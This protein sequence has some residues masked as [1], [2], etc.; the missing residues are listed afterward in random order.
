MNLGSSQAGMV[1][2][3]SVATIPSIP[4]R[5]RY[6]VLLIAFL[7]TMIHYLD[8]ACLSVAAPGMSKDLNLSRMQ[9]GYVFVAFDLAYAIFGIPVSWLGG[10]DRTAEARHRH[11]CYLVNPYDSH[12]IRSRIDR[13]SGNPLRVR[14]GGV[15]RISDAVKGLG[16][17][18][19]SRRTREG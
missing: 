14:R 16:T 11:R 12:G 6:W 4:S 3:S 9:M 7:A 8:R 15:W 19:S 17:M 2:N 1:S 18:V 10:P 13:P 5:T